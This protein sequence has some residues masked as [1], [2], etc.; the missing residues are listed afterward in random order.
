LS[1]VK[2]MLNRI[3]YHSRG[4][5]HRVFVCRGTSMAYKELL[6]IYFDDEHKV[7][8][9]HPDCDLP[10]AS[11]FYSFGRLSTAQRTALIWRA[12]AIINE[13]YKCHLILER[14]SDD[15]LR[16][17][18]DMRLLTEFISSP[19]ANVNYGKLPVSSTW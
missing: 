2:L 19:S 4:Y 13:Y 10:V 17:C 16:L 15:Y 14:S 3:D 1:I 6:R 12:V 5:S 7:F 11:L 9:S 18:Q 8:A